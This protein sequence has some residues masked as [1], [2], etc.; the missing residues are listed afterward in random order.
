MEDETT[1]EH[2]RCGCGHE[3]SR[4]MYAGLVEIDCPRCGRSHLTML[5]RFLLPVVKAASPDKSVTE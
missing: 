1:I 4:E 3:W 5:G 2:Y